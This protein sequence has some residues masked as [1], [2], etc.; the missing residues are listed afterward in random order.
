MKHI[1]II[2]A[3]VREGRLSHRVALFIQ[4]YIEENNLATVEILDLKAYDFPLFSERLM[5]QKN[6]SEKVLDFADRFNKA[7]GVIIV[8]PVYNAS[9]PAALKNVIDLFVKEWRDK[10][11]AV[12]S[13]TSGDNAGIAT[14]LQI[15]SL[16]IKLGALVVPASY[17]AIKAETGYD[18]KGN[19]T[20]EIAKKRIDA[21][22]RKLLQLVEQM[23]KR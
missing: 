18:E 16:L 5:F 2:S 4:K 22:V 6:P 19:A 11:I 12:A 17:T 8:S 1:A 21:F 15:Q 20:E 13:V 3:S 10:I 23:Q 9:F 7:D 14:A